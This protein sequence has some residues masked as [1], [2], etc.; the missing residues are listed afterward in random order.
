MQT[1]HII[2]FFIKAVIVGAIAFLLIVFVRPELLNSTPGDLPAVPTPSAPEQLASAAG[3]GPVSY[4]DAVE[5][6]APA[7]VNIYTAKIVARKPNSLLED[8][9][10]KF[11]FGQQ[12][13]RPQQRRQNSLGSGVIVDADG[14]I[15]TNNHV[16]AGADEIEVLLRDGRS[17]RASVVGTDP[18]TDL[19]VLKIELE[20]L[21]H[22]NLAS[23]N[24]RV[25]DVVLAIGNPFGVGQTVTQGIISATGRNR[26]GI[27]TF[28]NF[29]QT[30]AAI[31]PGN[32]GGA[33]VNARG[34]LV[35]INTA[36]FSRSG[37]SQ[38]IGFS[39][40]VS[41]A[42]LVTDQ[43]TEHGRPV[44][45]FLGIEAQDITAEIAES[46]DLQ[47]VRGV[48]V[49]GILRD[50]PAD[51]AGLRPGDIITHINGQ[52]IKD[53]RTV[54]EEITMNKPGSSIRVSGIREGKALETR[55]V[56]G[57]RPAQRP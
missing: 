38:G 28:E 18:E 29:I 20:N 13:Q 11:F 56:I 16:V 51:Q 48:I 4:S 52:P 7:V 5:Q 25:G 34:Q 27:N 8:P 6:A 53:S 9:L 54:L 55:A 3:I 22:M 17:T 43:I 26:L 33:L 30:D 2:T 24:V 35:G 37:G 10:F 36:I 14:L 57:E 23:G 19:A 42:K 45:G 1:G 15:L 49:A 39:I 31:N 46:F 47:D 12:N 50:G 21:P 44:R 40:P 32:S 41:L